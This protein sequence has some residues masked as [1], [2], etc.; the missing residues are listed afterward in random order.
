[1][2]IL[3]AFFAWRER[4]RAERDRL[5]ADNARLREALQKI[6]NEHDILSGNYGDVMDPRHIK[7]D[8]WPDAANKA[9]SAL[10][11]KE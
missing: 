6:L 2:N 4:R 7:P 8:R 1:M 10:A 3:S 5:A 11:G 9:R